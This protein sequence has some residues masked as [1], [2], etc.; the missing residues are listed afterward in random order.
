MNIENIEKNLLNKSESEIVNEKILNLFDKIENYQEISS[1]AKEILLEKINS[2][3]LDLLNDGSGVN[4][5]FM[6]LGQGEKVQ[7]E[8]LTKF[9]KEIFPKANFDIFYKNDYVN[10][11]ELLSKKSILIGP[12]DYK[13]EINPLQ[14]HHGDLPSQSF[15]TLKEI[16]IQ[17]SMIQLKL[18]NKATVKDDDKEEL[19]KLII[20][21]P[22][23]PNEI[24]EKMQNTPIV[25]TMENDPNRPANLYDNGIKKIFDEEKSNDFKQFMSVSADNDNISVNFIDNGDYLIPKTRRRI[26]EIDKKLILKY[27]Y[28]IGDL[29]Y[30][31]SNRNKLEA[32]N[33]APVFTNQGVFSSLNSNESMDEAFKDKILLISHQEKNIVQDN[34]KKA[35]NFTPPSDEERGIV[36]KKIQQESLVKNES[37]IQDLM[38]QIIKEIKKIQKKENN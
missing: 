4:F 2:K 29:S 3:E 13:E 31:Q 11:R 10:K 21:H 34:M 22:S 18:L 12:R 6:A 8:F 37:L 26:C 32:I 38:P 17:P 36:L 24:K 14:A 7:S 5:V 19:K 1:F 35:K 30:V 33:F 16:K 28:S 20:N 15:D 27:L 25:V 23:I 9:L